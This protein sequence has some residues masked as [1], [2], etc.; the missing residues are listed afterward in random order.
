MPS[1][2]TITLEIR[3]RK[4]FRSF[5]ESVKRWS[6]LIV[7]RRAGKTYSALQ[8]LLKCAL[9]H[10]RKGPPKRYAYIAPTRDQAKDIAW[11]YL[12][13]FT[14]ALPGV[15]KNEADLTI[16]FSDG[17]SIR[18]YSGENYERMRG[19]YFDGVVIDEPED[20]DPLAWP[21][22]IRPTLTDYQGWAI[23]IG[24]VKGK[25]GQ[26]KRLMDAMEDPEWF[27]LLLKAS[28]SKIIPE[29][30]LASIRRDA[31][32]SNRLEI[33]DQEYECDPNIGIPGTLFANF[34]TDAI[35]TGR[36]ID[37]PWERGE[38]VWTFWDLGSPENMRCTYVQF[39][40]REIHI[41]D[42]DADLRDPEMTP[43]KR[44]AH[45]RSKG[46]PY[47]GHFFPHDAAAREKSGL[48]FQQQMTLAGLEGIRIIP[49]CRSIWPGVNKLAEL[50]PRLVFNKSQTNYL[51]ESLE[52][53]K[54]KIDK[55]G[56]VTDRIHEDWACHSTDSMRMMAEAML[57]GL[58]KGHSEVIRESRQSNRPKKASAGKYK[59]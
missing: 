1:N 59:P 4:Q 21:A 49:V 12:K 58:L 29:E 55:D 7:H 36:V 22:V 32:R 14:A 25:K 11:G 44:V 20:I 31:I 15:Q 54:R 46:Y 5:L 53:Y 28:E 13:A 27:S 47:G 10:Q 38:L 2:N 34:V 50:F 17:T 16:T 6:C 37:Y 42:H 8:K 30:E 51:L 24:T 33:Y 39:V 45:M 18:L 56:S 48:N 41:I 43:A 57:N 19:L 26:W 40:G 3:P 23:W 9:T 52:N 35:R